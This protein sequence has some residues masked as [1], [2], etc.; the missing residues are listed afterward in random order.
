M[1]CKTFFQVSKFFVIFALLMG[2]GFYS[3]SVLAQGKSLT[4][5]VYQEGSWSA[6]QG[7]WISG[8]SVHVVSPGV[9]PFDQTLTTGND[10]KAIFS[11]VP[12]GSYEITVSK[13][14]CG[15]N[16]KPYQMPAYDAITNLDLN[17]PTGKSLTVQVYQKGTWRGGRGKWIA[18]ANVMVVSRGRNTPAYE[19]KTKTDSNGKAVFNNVPVGDY[20]VTV[21]KKGCGQNSR[22]YRMP[23][24]DATTNL[25]LNCAR[26]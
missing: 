6:G 5:Q 12:V 4:V 13:A 2:F 11:N 21:A 16:S 25:E 20:K 18:D 1:T 14:N 10:G 23:A 24:Y 3:S 8:A 26:K 22:N 15:E 17:C 9:S 7:D 19:S